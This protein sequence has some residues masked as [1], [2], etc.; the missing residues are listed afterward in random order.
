MGA[1]PARQAQD[2]WPRHYVF[3]SCSVIR[4]SR[5]VLTRRGFSPFQLS[6]SH[7]TLDGACSRRVPRKCIWSSGKLMRSCAVYHD[8]DADELF[9]AIMNWIL[10]L[11]HS[12]SFWAE[13]TLWI[14]L[15][16]G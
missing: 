5:V 4:V 15:F 14:F 13:A 6:R 1:L 2:A 16:Q 3:V 7:Q 11:L 9:I 8:V 10:Q 12:A